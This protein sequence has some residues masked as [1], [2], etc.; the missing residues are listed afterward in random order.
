MSPLDRPWDLTSQLFCG[1]NP[2]S[3]LSIRKT[4]PKEPHVAPLT[5][6]SQKAQYGAFRRYCF[7]SCLNFAETASRLELRNPHDFL[8]RWASATTF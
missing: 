5:H 1:K 3:L 2:F 8:K 6:E 4:R 7:R